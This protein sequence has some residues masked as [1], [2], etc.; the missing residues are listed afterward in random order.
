[1]NDSEQAYAAA[2]CSRA[3]AADLR[4]C[5]PRSRSQLHGE[6]LAYAA[7]PHLQLRVSVGIAHFGNR[8]C[9]P[10]SSLGV[11][12]RLNQWPRRQVRI[13]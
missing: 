7:R 9:S 13:E 12:S 11:R 3:P 10:T 8:N 2:S 1:M 6:D 4:M 5:K